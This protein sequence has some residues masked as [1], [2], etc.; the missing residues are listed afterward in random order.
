MLSRVDHSFQALLH[1]TSPS[2]LNKL[3]QPKLK[4]EIILSFNVST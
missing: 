3:L 1:L 4:L 2:K